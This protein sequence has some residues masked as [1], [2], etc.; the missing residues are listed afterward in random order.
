[1]GIL[2]CPAFQELDSHQ[3]IEIA[4]AL[5]LVGDIEQFAIVIGQVHIVSTGAL[6]W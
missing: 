2:G 5:I 1:M 6:E 4:R 3:V